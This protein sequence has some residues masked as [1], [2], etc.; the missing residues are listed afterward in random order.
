MTIGIALGLL[1]LLLVIGLAFA[2]QERARIPD[3]ARV[4]GVEDSIVFVSNGLT[5]SARDHLDRHDVR[6][7][8]EWSVRY[9]QDP[10]VRDEPDAPVEFA[11][12]DM[13][14]Y[15]QRNTVS[16]GRVYEEESILQVLDLQAAYLDA[17]DA[18]G[19]PAED[20]AIS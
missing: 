19:D 2:W 13:R 17:I 18:F 11:G 12:V 16:A 14:S 4:Y 15:V 3:R 1:G 10:R 7:I 9:L 8:L 5:G 20:G 6:R